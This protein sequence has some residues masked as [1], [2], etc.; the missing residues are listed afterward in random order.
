MEEEEE[1]E[2]E[3]KAEEEEEVEE[4]KGNDF[5]AI[6]FFGVSVK[7]EATARGRFS[8]FSSAEDCCC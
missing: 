3:E 4:A 2:E 6:F 5:R 1:E 8:S 7:P